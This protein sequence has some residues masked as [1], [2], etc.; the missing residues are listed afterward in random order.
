MEKGI[1][2]VGLDV[3]K[4]TNAVA[5]ADGSGGAPRLL[6]TIPN[7]PEAVTRLMRKLGPAPSLRVCYEAGPCGYG[8]ERQF[9]RLA[10]PPSTPRMRWPAE[11]TGRNS[12]RPWTVPRMAAFS[13]SGT[14]P[15]L[16]ALPAPAFAAD[17]PVAARLS[18]D[19]PPASRRRPLVRT[20]PL[21]A[22]SSAS[23]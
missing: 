19:R 4:E 22:T 6:G 14:E 15:T 2:F 21:G 10:R 3:R 9:S 7:R 1:T 8:L 11:E 16:G 18:R 17:S 5:V 13:S 12:V 20:A 23:G